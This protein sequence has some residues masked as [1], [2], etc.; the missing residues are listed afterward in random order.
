M[1]AEW[2]IGR[3]FMSVREKQ[4]AREAYAARPLE[5]FVYDPQTQ[6]RY[7]LV[8]LLDQDSDSETYA[9]TLDD[10]ERPTL[11]IK[12]Y[13]AP[14]ARR[15]REGTPDLDRDS[16]AER[17]KAPDP[18]YSNPAV[19]T[20]FGI[21]AVLRQRLGEQFCETLVVC[22]IH[23][24]YAPPPDTNATVVFY[25]LE[26]AITLSRWLTGIQYRFMADYELLRA[27]PEQRE[28]A[29]RFLQLIRWRG[30]L[31]AIELF[32][33][34]SFLHQAGVYH[35]DV[36]P[37]NIR[38]LLGAGDATRVRLANFQHS[39]A[40]SIETED[41]E[42]VFERNKD[43]LGCT[44]RYRSPSIIFRD[45][46]SETPMPETSAA[47]SAVQAISAS[48]EVYSLGKILQCLFD[49]RALRDDQIVVRPT[50]FMP[51]GLDALIRSMTG[52][53]GY[54][55]P[56]GTMD[57]DDNR[58]ELTAVEWS[59]RRDNLINARPT[60]S[61]VYEQLRELAGQQE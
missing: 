40:T 30:M 45:P 36:Q 15:R 23:R 24:F 27:D 34:F 61:W 2:Q 35:G 33:I 14:E 50:R 10:N 56:P 26:R 22:A 29:V 41:S 54:R 47:T 25:P 18:M 46:L 37:D 52:E 38:V 31:V 5:G 60:V 17:T 12:I 20:E 11:S 19:E 51:P 4:A 6:Q 8:Y 59:R 13:Y 57:S 7:D 16:E 1:T 53:N 39:C 42:S 32:S 48:F 21:S 28:R 43:I 44:S 49:P 3:E 9:A 58:I 55:A